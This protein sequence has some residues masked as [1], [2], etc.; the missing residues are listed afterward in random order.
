MRHIFLF[1]LIIWHMASTQH[2]GGN[3]LPESSN[4]YICDGMLILGLLVYWCT[5]HKTND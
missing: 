2:F 4:E 3:L 5:M 1:I